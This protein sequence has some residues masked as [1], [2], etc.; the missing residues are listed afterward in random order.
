[1]RADPGLGKS[2][3]LARI[4]RRALVSPT[5]CAAAQLGPRRPPEPARVIR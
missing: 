4:P 1:M 2:V 3:D 5:G